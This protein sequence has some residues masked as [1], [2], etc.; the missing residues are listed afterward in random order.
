V[1]NTDTVR[2]AF[3]AVEANDVDTYV[4]LFADD[5]VYQAANFPPVIGPEGIKR[6]AAPVMET[7]SRVTHDV[8]AMWEPERDVVIAEVVLTYERKDGK[9]TKLPCLDVIQLDGGKIKSLRA[10]LDLSPAFA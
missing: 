5:A 1:S 6:F 4:S 3:A 7:F 10:Y 2:R 9:V 8:K